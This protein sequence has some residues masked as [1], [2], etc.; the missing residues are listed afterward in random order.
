VTKT[1]MG[2]NLLQPLEILTELV[3]EQISQHLT[4]LAVLDVTVSIQ[5]PVRDLILPG[6]LHDGDKLLNLLFSKFTSSLVQRN[7]C[8][9]HHNI[10]VSSANTLDGSQGI[11][12]IGFTINIRVEHTKNVLEVGGNY[13]RHLL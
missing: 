11:H 10:G 7:I 9:L 4:G 2:T 3:V 5:E 12:G 13:Q 6:V 8:L 1:T